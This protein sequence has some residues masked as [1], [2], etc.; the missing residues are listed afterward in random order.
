MIIDDQPNWF[1]GRSLAI[2]PTDSNIVY[3]GGFHYRPGGSSAIGVVKTTDGWSEDWAITPLNSHRGYAYSVAVDPKDPRT[4]YAAGHYSDDG[5]NW[6]IALFKTTNGGEVWNESSSGMDDDDQPVYA[7]AIDPDS[8]NTV[9][10]GTRGGVY[11]TS[12][13]G[14]NWSHTHCGLDTV[15]AL[16]ILPSSSSTIYAGTAQG[17]YRSVD[18]GSNWSPASGGLTVVDVSSLGASAAPL[19]R[20]YVG[21]RGG[22]VFGQDAVVVDEGEHPGSAPDIFGVRADGSHYPNQQLDENDSPGA[23]RCN[24]R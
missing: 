10:A 9:Y 4:V 3:G 6:H 22:G 15:N 19:E 11:K 1:S 7:L 12:D 24:T 5:R 17:V 8:T 18:R 21:T 14:S 20:I 2:D 13:G 16:L 23:A